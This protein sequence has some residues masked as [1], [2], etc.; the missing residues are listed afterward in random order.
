[1]KN[2]KIGIAIL[3][4]SILLAG[5]ASSIKEDITNTK[6]AQSQMMNEITG[7]TKVLI[8]YFSR[9]GNIDST[10]QVDVTSSASVVT[11]GEDI[12]GNL[13]Y[14][15]KLIRNVTGGDLYFIETANKYPSEYD[16]SDKNA[17]DLQA[18]KENKENVR[19]ALMTHKDNLDIYDVVFL[20]FP[21]WYGD[22]PMAV[23]SFLEEFNL[24][25]KR[26]Y[27]FNSS[28]GGGARDSYTKVAALQ[29]NAIVEKHIL[30]VRHSQV[31]QLTN[32]SIQDWLNDINYQP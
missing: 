1:M 7:N 2:R 19:P 17:L 26:I 14:M 6:A 5:C 21:N 10:H 16:D 9:I 31:S 32:E 12:L 11:Q 24:S 18:N 13:E 22:M 8:A 23:Y 25:N 20:G 29:P 28:G 3:T 27:L 30:S 4:L 15:A